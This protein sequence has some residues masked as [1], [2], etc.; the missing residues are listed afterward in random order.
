MPVPTNAASQP[1]AS[2]IC[3]W[4]ALGVPSTASTRSSRA[5]NDRSLED[6]RGA[7]WSGTGRRYRRW[8]E[9]AVKPQRIVPEQL[10]LRRL[11]QIPGHHRVHRFWKPA[12]AVRVV[13]RVHQDVFAQELDDGLRQLHA[14]RHLDGLEESTGGDVV[15]RLLLERRQGPS[16]GPGLLVQALSP[17]RQPPVAGLEHSQPKIRIPDEHTRADEGGHVANVAPGVRSRAPEPPVL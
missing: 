10:A 12:F 1:A 11:R 16:H 13:R 3:A 4:K 2:M 6:G 14:F 17:E 5:R 8:S 9:T 15:A 7:R